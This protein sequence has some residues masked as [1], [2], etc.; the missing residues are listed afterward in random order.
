MF[1]ICSAGMEKG[2]RTP[3]LCRTSGSTSDPPFA[4][5]KETINEKKGNT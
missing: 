1:L 2:G 3:V 5:K 4:I